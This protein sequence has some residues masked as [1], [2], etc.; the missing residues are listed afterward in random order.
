[1]TRKDFELIART[2]RDSLAA[3]AVGGRGTDYYLDIVQRFVDSLSTTN[4]L[5]N[6]RKFALAA[7]VP[8][9]MIGLV[10]PS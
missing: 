4:P 2:I 5:F 6:W 3:D 7:G 1:M 9:N 10:G 8:I